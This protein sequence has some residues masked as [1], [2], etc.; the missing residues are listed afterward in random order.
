M[1][2]SLFTFTTFNW[3]QV[4]RTR[5]L[6]SGSLIKQRPDRTNVCKNSKCDWRD[7][8]NTM[9][10]PSTNVSVNKEQCYTLRETLNYKVN[11]QLNYQSINPQ[12][13]QSSS[14]W[15]FQKSSTLRCADW[16]QERKCTCNKKTNCNKLSIY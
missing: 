7:D 14:S 13:S 12:L 9:I 11:L 6:F 3:I 5:S 8:P 15:T 10:Q 1:S 2:G 16:R 4:S